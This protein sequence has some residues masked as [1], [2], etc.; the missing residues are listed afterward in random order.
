MKHFRKLAQSVPGPILIR[1]AAPLL[2]LIALAD[3]LSAEETNRY[4]A[5][6]SFDPIALLMPPP[7]PD[8][9]EQAGDLAEVRWVHTHHATNEEAAAW[10]EAGGISLANFTPVVGPFFQPGKLPRTKAFFRK[11]GQDNKLL[12]DQVKDH[13]KRQRPYVV[14]PDLAQGK[15]VAGGSYPSGHSTLSMTLALVLAEIF[16]EKRDDLLTAARSIGWHRV[17]IAKH[18][19]TDVFAGRVLAQAIVRELKANPE[20]QRDL[21]E[22]KAELTAARDQK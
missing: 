2:L 13:W 3:N 9:A 10:A 17:V 11:V 18:F 21:A 6:S 1:F 14:D 16:P 20:F 4:L 19:P 12:V 15:P 5:A 7:L 8:S 22:V